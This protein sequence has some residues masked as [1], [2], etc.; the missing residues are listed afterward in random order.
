MLSWLFGKKKEAPKEKLRLRFHDAHILVTYPDGC[1]PADDND[2]WVVA[3]R[4]TE[5]YRK[6]HYPE[7]AKRTRGIVR[8]L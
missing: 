3:R 6:S 4:I 5:S 1:G 7:A 8:C 2:N